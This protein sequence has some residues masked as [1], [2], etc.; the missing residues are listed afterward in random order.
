M[1]LSFPTIVLSACIGVHLRPKINGR[2]W[3]PMHAD[4]TIAEKLSDTGRFRLPS[5]LADFLHTF[6]C[7]EKLPDLAIRTALDP[8]PEIREYADVRRIPGLPLGRSRSRPLHAGTRRY[9]PPGALIPSR[10]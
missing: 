6:E 9:R 5:P 8:S 7:L 1:P 4:N 3:T 2:G 10:E